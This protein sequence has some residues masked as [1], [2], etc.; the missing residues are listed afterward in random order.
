MA[1]SQNGDRAPRQRTGRS[2][3]GKVGL[4]EIA[5][6]AGVS[7]ATVSRVMNRKY[8][9]SSTT[10]DA[11]EAAMHSVGYERP[12]RGRIVMVLVPGLIDPFFGALATE[13]EIAL[14]PHGLWSVVCPVL[15]STVL[16][17][18]FVESMLDTGVSAA[19]FL[20]SSNTLEHSDSHTQQLLQSRRIP[21]VSINGG[22]ASADLPVVS[23]D[24]WVA[25]EIAVGH[26]YDLGHRR[27]G[28]CAGPVGNIPADRRVEGFVQAMDRRNLP[29]SEDSI[30]RQHFSFDGGHQAATELLTMGITGIVASSDQMAL[31][32]IRAARRAG[33][34]VPEDISVVGYNDSRD[35]EYMDPPLTTVRQ[36]VERLAAS[37]VRAIVA[38]ISNRPV[39]RE[40]LLIDPELRVRRSTAPLVVTNA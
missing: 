13:I 33:L 36:P 35:L 15:P 24:D 8:G 12:I 14:A 2:P 16:E 10:R 31:G 37:T 17:Q 9:V 29:D 34:R 4:A 39:S 18:N 38:M 7:E 28:M 25:A 40:E 27:I 20:S 1:E 3:A 26:L 23:T 21:Y 19:V 32:A 22:H 5:Q 11:V 30:I 6:I